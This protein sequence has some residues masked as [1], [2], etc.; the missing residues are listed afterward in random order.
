MLTMK[1]FITTLFVL[2]ILLGAVASAFLGWRNVLRTQQDSRTS[3][4]RSVCSTIGVVL[5]SLS[6]LLFLAYGVRNALTGGD[7]NGNWTTLYFIRTGNYLSLTGAITSLIGKGN[8]R[9]LA[10]L[11]GCLMLFMWS[12]AG[13]SL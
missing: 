9:W 8:A 4:W 10:F 12:S 13:M 7:G 11:S 3:R 6:V 2:L 1:Q 5:V